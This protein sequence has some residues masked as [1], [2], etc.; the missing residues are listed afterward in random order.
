MQTI[1]SLPRIKRTFQH[2]TS[3]IVKLCLFPLKTIEVILGDLGLKCKK[4]QHTEVPTTAD[5]LSPNP[6]IGL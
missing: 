1:N 3:Q 6:Q 5:L 2:R 4:Y